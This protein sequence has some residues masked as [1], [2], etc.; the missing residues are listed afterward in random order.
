M[1]IPPVGVAESP[2]P[3]QVPR[4]RRAYEFQHNQHNIN[5]LCF[6]LMRSFKHGKGLTYACGIAQKY[7]EFFPGWVLLLEYVST[8]HLDQDA[9]P[10]NYC[11]ASNARFNKRT[12]TRGSP[13]NPN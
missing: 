11:I 9:V 10:S 4:S 1:I 2:K 12:L 7:F 8:V 13:K 3:L 5:A 6:A